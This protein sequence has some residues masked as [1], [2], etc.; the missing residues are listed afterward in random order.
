MDG[1]Y[2]VGTV[3]KGLYAGVGEVREPLNG[4]EGRVANLHQLLLIEGGR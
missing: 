4:G 2:G 1:R 3:Q